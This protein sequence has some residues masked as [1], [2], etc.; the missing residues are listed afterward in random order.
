[1]SWFKSASALENQLSQF[2]YSIWELQVVFI[3]VICSFKILSLIAQWMITRREDQLNKMWS[4]CTC[5]RKKNLSGK[6]EN[7]STLIQTICFQ[8]TCG[9]FPLLCH[10]WHMSNLST[11]GNWWI[12]CINGC[13]WA[14]RYKIVATALLRLCNTTEELCFI[15]VANC[16]AYVFGV[17]HAGIR[18]TYPQLHAW[19]ISF[20]CPYTCAPHRSLFMFVPLQFSLTR[21]NCTSAPPYP[22]ACG[23]WFGVSFISFYN[24]SQSCKSIA[25]KR[26]SIDVWL[27]K[28]LHTVQCKPYQNTHQCAHRILTTNGISMQ[29]HIVIQCVR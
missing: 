27:R 20:N 10:G 23:V 24:S 15:I 2:R 6:H 26:N 16:M 1:M 19:I 21:F 17:L 12:A 22:H 18:Y 28:R 14:L 5:I 7:I 9:W 29:F 13:M 11:W 3:I 4:S 8:F 25:S